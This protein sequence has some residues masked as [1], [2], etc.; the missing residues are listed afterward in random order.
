MTRIA[1]P[2]QKTSVGIGRR[3]RPRPA[4]GGWGGGFTLFELLVAMAILVVLAAILLPVL[5]QAREMGRRALC[6]SNLKQIGTAVIM[7]AQDV[8]GILPPGALSYPDPAGG[9]AGE[10]YVLVQPYLHSRQVL[11]CPT[12][13]SA[14]L[15]A[16]GWN[17]QNFGYYYGQHGLGWCTVRAQVERP[18]E[19]ILLGDSE[20]LEAR[21]IANNRYLYADGGSQRLRAAR[22]SGGG[23]YWYLDGHARHHRRAFLQGHL[24]LFTQNPN[25]Q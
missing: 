22:H 10:W 9:D 7:Y 13:P 19:T 3:N 17:Y 20:D 24:G 5:S 11:C 12:K 1:R 16:Y 4:A 15:I 23:D 18:A 25:D 6:V 21:N 14:N 2:P 8:D